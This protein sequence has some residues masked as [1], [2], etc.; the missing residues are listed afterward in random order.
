MDLTPPRKFSQQIYTIH[1]I[2]LVPLKNPEIRK[3]FTRVP[4]EQYFSNITARPIIFLG[5]EDDAC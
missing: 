3:T 4:I 2:G 1:E 5:Y